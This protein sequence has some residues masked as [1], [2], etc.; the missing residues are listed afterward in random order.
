MNKTGKAA[1]LAALA[2]ALAACGGEQAKTENTATP[3][4]DEASSSEGAVDKIEVSAAELEGNPFL[5]TWDTPYGAPPFSE[6]LDEHYMPAIKAAILDLRAEIEAITNNPDA[7]TFENTIVALDLAGK[8]LNK[9]SSTFGNI[10]NTD[11]N[12]AL[13]ALESEIY[14]MLTREFNNVRFDRGAIRTR[15]CGLR[16]ERRARTR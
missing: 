16:A 15:Q 3:S 4:A 5:A 14:P 10:T 8:Q 11:T 1:L 12:D 7:P 2:T 9:V 6:I 13:R